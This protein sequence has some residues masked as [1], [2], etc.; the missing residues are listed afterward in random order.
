MGFLPVILM[1]DNHSIIIIHRMT[2]GPMNF[3][4]E[5]RIHALAL[6]PWCAR[7]LYCALPRLVRAIPDRAPSHLYVTCVSYFKIFIFKIFIFFCPP[8]AGMLA[9]YSLS[10]KADSKR[11]TKKQRRKDNEKW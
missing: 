1:G 6:G 5:F 10:I 2:K 11:I 9:G 4:Q 3:E 8:D 7:I